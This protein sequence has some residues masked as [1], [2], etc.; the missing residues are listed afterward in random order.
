[1]WAKGGGLLITYSLKT[2]NLNYKDYYS[3]IKK[4]G[5]M[6]MEKSANEAKQY[7]DDFKIYLK[8]NNIE[9]LKDDKYYFIEIILIGVLFEEYKDYISNINPCISLICSILN[10]KRDSKLK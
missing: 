5:T 9:N 1:M 10:K 3:I 8:N 4:L 6:L 7:I 2:Q